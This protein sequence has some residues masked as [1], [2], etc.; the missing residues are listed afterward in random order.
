MNYNEIEQESFKKSLYDNKRFWWRNEVKGTYL[1]AMRLM[2]RKTIKEISNLI[3]EDPFILEDIES[4]LDLNAPPPIVGKYMMV[5]SI[6]PSHMA[7]FRKIMKGELKGFSEKRTITQ[8]TKRKV[9]N[10][11]NNKCAHCGEEKELHFHHIEKYSDGG[12][13]T[14]DNLMLLCKYCHAKEHEGESY[15]NL[16]YS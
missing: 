13:N 15:Q 10:K 6:T 1:Y 9:R 16:I 3:N 5:L 12:Q 4:R 7:Q 8:Y 2:R 11:Y 14:E